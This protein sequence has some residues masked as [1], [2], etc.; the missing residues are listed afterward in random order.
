MDQV[1]VIRVR[2]IFLS[3]KII[4]KR[5]AAFCSYC[6][7]ALYKR[8]IPLQ[9]A[10]N[11]NHPSSTFSIVKRYGPMCITL[12]CILGTGIPYLVASMNNCHCPQGFSHACYEPDHGDCCSCDG[13]AFSCF[14]TCEIGSNTT[15]FEYDKQVPCSGT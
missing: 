1:I 9:V 2:P 11:N 14:W 4:S 6:I 3:H 15:C 12:I 13:S 10:S 8:M 5:S 7:L